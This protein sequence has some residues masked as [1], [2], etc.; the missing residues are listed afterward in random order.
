MRAVRRDSG[1]LPPHLV[2]VRR[3]IRVRAVLDL[4]L[5]VSQVASALRISAR[6]VLR[7]LDRHRMCRVSRR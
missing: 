6:T 4:K 1:E 5:P 7:V 3:E 2:S